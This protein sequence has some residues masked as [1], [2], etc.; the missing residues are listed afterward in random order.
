MASPAWLSVRRYSLPGVSRFSPSRGASVLS[1][2]PEDVCIDTGL[3]KKAKGRPRTL[4]VEQ[5]KR[6]KNMARTNPKSIAW[7]KAN[8]RVPEIHLKHK[9]PCACHLCVQM[10]C[11]HCGPE[12]PIVWTGIGAFSH[13]VYARHRT[14]HDA[15]Y[16]ERTLMGNVRKGQ[17]KFTKLRRASE[18]VLS[19]SKKLRAAEELE[20]ASAVGMHAVP[21]DAINDL[22]RDQIKKFLGAVNRL[23]GVS[24]K[25]FMEAVSKVDDGFKTKNDYRKAL[26]LAKVVTEEATSSG[27]YAV[28]ERKVYFDPRVSV[29]IIKLAYALDRGYSFIVHLLLLYGLKALSA[30]LR[31]EGITPPSDVVSIPSPADIV[32]VDQLRDMAE[33]RRLRFDDDAELIAYGEPDGESLDAA[34]RRLLSDFSSDFEV[35]AE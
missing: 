23:P 13:H 15:W 25:L 6:L 19:L 11:L 9:Q 31:R 33:K 3:P 35:E 27:K 24:R 32:L 34:V 21:L 16:T 4:R 28:L 29:E 30:G 8:P 12:V 10:S 7:E 22:T 1:E 20:K 26:E 17:S 14:I 2:P 18:E 5:R